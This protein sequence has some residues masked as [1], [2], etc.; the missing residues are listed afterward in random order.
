MGTWLCFF[1]KALTSLCFFFFA[2]FLFS[3]SL[4]SSVFFGGGKEL[5]M[6]IVVKGITAIG[7]PIYSMPSGLALADR[8]ART[9]GSMMSGEDSEVVPI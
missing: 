1:Y 7:F 5:G 3:S 6:G 4:S 8:L 9:S 2:I